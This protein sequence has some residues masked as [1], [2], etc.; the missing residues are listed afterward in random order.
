VAPFDAC[1]RQLGHKGI[2]AFIV[3]VVAV[4]REDLLEDDGQEVK[5]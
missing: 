3:E 2:P 4:R 1:R 5:H